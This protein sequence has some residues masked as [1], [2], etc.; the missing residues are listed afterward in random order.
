M[1]EPCEVAIVSWRYRYCPSPSVRLGPVAAGPPC[2]GVRPRIVTSPTT[3][4]PTRTSATAP[5]S[6]RSFRRLRSR[7]RV[8]RSNGSSGPG[9]RPLARRSRSPRSLILLTHL[10]PQ[11]FPP[12]GGQHP[13]RH[14]TDAKGLAGLLGRQAKAVDQNDGRPLSGRE[15]GK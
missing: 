3:S 11:Y 4:P 9:T 5:A 6:S 14:R 8:R 2:P 13:N 7:R 12:P 15:R 1:I 10:S